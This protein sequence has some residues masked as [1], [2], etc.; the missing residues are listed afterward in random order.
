MCG[1]PSGET[2]SLDAGGVP[3]DG[4]P[5]A[6]GTT[7]RPDAMALDATADDAMEG[8]ATALDAGV[9]DDVVLPPIAQFVGVTTRTWTDTTRPTP[10]N[11]SQPAQSSRTLVT[12][13]WYPTNATSATPPTI[14]DAPL[15]P[16]GPYPLVLMVHGSSSTR[17][18]STFLTIGLA[19]AG[20]VVAAADF[21]LTALTT[22]GGPSDL[23]VSYQ[24]GD[25][26]FLCDSLEAASLDSADAL[27]GAIA[28]DAYAVVGHSTGGTVA[29]L[30]AFA[31][32]D[33]AI[34]HDPRVR[35]VVPLSGDACMFA[36]GFFKSRSVPMLAIGATDDLFVPLADNGQWAFSNSGPPHL[37]AKL[38]GGEHMGFT[39]IGLPDGLL[40][41]VPTGPTSPL[42][43]TLSAYGDASACLPVPEAGTD[44]LMPQATQH[45]L[46]VQLVRAYLD[47]Q[48]RGAPAQLG[49]LLAANNPLLVFEQ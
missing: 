5:A 24:V 48:L 21:P 40:G 9:A 46:V 34:K 19:Q 43:T 12:E 15:A 47:A 6:D 11:G 17:T 8:D 18:V 30:A 44:P 2:D 28:G 35:A 37:L 45:D 22:P 29:Q 31:G 4:A 36:P 41:P 38:V 3:A 1:G 49:A 10:Q 25:L 20:Y 7:P 16:G 39:D 42:A 26:A 13:V 27:H 23:G 33:A 32:D 14:R